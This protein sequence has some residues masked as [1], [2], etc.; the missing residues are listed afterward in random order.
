MKTVFGIFQCTLEQDGGISLP[1]WLRAKLDGK[2]L[3]GWVYPEEARA[4]RVG[5]R[6]GALEREAEK[7]G[8]VLQPVRMEDG[9]LLLP[10]NLL[11]RLTDRELV[12]M[13]T[14]SFLEIWTRSHWE[15]TTGT[16]LSRLE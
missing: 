3:C 7:A 13:G 9:R 11:T 6:T 1:E 12:L 14:P 5:A 2:T 15:E 16:M 4:V 8:A 10:A